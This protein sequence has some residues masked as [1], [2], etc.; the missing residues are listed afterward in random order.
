MKGTTPL[1]TAGFYNAAV[2]AASK[3]LLYLRSAIALRS[4]NWAGLPLIPKAF[5][6]ELPY[7][8]HAY[9]SF[10]LWI[11]RLHLTGCRTVV[12][13][14]ANHGDFARAANAVFPEARVFL[15]EPLPVMQEYL[16]NSIKA[17]RKNWHLAP[18]A[19]GDKPGE[20]PLVVDDQ[21]D[22]IG[23]FVGFTEDYLRA[24]PRARPA[25]E[26]LCRVQ[27]LDDATQDL[28]VGPIDLLKIDVEGFEFQVLNGGENALR[29]TEAIIVEVSL[30]RRT[31]EAEH[32]LVAML[33]ILCDRGFEVVEIIPSLYDATLAWK[34][35]E[36]N[37]L[38]RRANRGVNA[39]R[40]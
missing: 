40:E 35:A 11:K 23:S 20:F 12:D 28:N 10:L 33:Q 8:R 2:N 29:R 14:G 13:V 7:S 19:L 3:L 6:N 38:M 15:F 18:C 24:N 9:N 16:S 22:A 30:V 26:I 27:T 31:S 34:P 36:F 39:S 25:R 37:V 32:P 21:D 4:L 17:G 1:E 5:S